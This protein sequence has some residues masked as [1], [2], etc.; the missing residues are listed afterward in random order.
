[1]VN[2]LLAQ[3]KLQQRDN[4]PEN[5]EAEKRGQEEIALTPQNIY[6]K[7]CGLTYT[8]GTKGICRP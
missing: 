3:A 5:M 8:A 1:M 2:T 6:K 4:S 7:A